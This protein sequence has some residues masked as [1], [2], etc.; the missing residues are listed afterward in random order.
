MTLTNYALRSDAFRI[1]GVRR[2]KKYLPPS[3]ACS[4]DPD[5]CDADRSVST[6]LT[7]LYYRLSMVVLN[8]LDSK[9]PGMGFGCV[10]ESVFVCTRD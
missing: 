8:E 7:I 2:A 1:N 4:F 5:R 10:E 9:T 6:Q 3:Y